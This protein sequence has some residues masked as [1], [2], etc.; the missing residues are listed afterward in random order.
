MDRLGSLGETHFQEVVLALNDPKPTVR[1]AAAFTVGGAAREPEM[2]LPE[3]SMLLKDNNLN[4]V[5]A[6]TWAV[7]RYGSV[8]SDVAPKVVGVLKLGLVRVQETLIE[9]AVDS[10]M[11]V[12]D[13]PEAVINEVFHE[14][15]VSNKDSA[16]HNSKAAA[17]SVSEGVNPIPVANLKRRIDWR[18]RNPHLLVSS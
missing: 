11:A 18:R 4:V 5:N 12:A 6:A 17:A 14:S 10:L 2:V 1:Q 7:G 13:D 16:R 15:L 9:Q 8:A 3:L